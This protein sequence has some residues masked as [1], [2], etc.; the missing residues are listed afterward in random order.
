M[1]SACLS[2]I[3]Y[4]VLLSSFWGCSK[5]SLLREDSPE[6]DALFFSGGWQSGEGYLTREDLI[7]MESF[8]TLKTQIVPGAGKAVLGVIPLKDLIAKLGLS[9][10]RDGIVLE[11]TV[12]DP[13]Q[14]PLHPIW[15]N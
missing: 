5:P 2:S 7:S 10:D 14:F 3:V 9:A 8:Q 6:E 1:K 11:C 4:T 13:F 15:A 12:P